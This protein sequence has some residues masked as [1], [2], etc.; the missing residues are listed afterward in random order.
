GCILADPVYVSIYPLIDNSIENSTGVVF[1]FWILFKAENHIF[2][3]ESPFSSYS[4][5]HCA[6]ASMDGT[7]VTECIYDTIS[8]CEDRIIAVGYTEEGGSVFF[9]VFDPEGNMLLSSSELSFADRLTGDAWDY[10]YAEG[11]YTVC[12]DNHTLVDPDPDLYRPDEDWATYY[13]NEAGELAFGPFYDA[14]LFS[15]GFARV[16]TDSDDWYFINQE[17]VTVSPV[18]PWCAS[19]RNGTVAVEI[20]DENENVIYQILNADFVPIIQSYNNIKQLEDGS[21][22]TEKEL[23]SKGDYRYATQCYSAG[24]A[25]IAELESA[26]FLSSKLVLLY[27]DDNTTVLKN[28]E[29]GKS[30]NLPG[31]VSWYLIGDPQNPYIELSYDEK[32]EYITRIITAD[33]EDIYTVP[34]ECYY[35]FRTE[36]GK[37]GT[38]VYAYEREGK[39]VL[40]NCYTGTEQTYPVSSFNTIET[41][42][43]GVLAVADNYTISYYNA[44]GELFF[45][46]PINPMDD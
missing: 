26:E 28:L 21:F 25:L 24:G 19:F 45:S 4:T 17:G 22:V 38:T 6:L 11:F 14:G 27:V 39:T 37:P 8:V 40:Y 43:N 18:Y 44:D 15:D 13:M 42:P 23:Y 34:E 16:N 1:P 36:P 2:E 10:M 46:Y 35:L 3:D 20:Y 9:D 30:L 31:Y 7:M 33:L 5:Y 29:T 32:E 41:Y 12:F